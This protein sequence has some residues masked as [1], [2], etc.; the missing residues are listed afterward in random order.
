LVFLFQRL[1]FMSELPVVKI[2]AVGLRLYMDHR[3]SESNRT[4]IR[5]LALR[6]LKD[7]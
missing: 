2:K 3:F 7:S 6:S 5:R 4:L 1:L